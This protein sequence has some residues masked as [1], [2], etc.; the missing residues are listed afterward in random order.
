VCSS[1]LIIISGGAV[2]FVGKPKGVTLEIRDYD[3][4]ES[5]EPENR[6]DCVKDES[7]DWYQRMFWDKNSKGYEDND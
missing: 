2:Q 4:E 1:D 6:S 7:G 3:I 5:D